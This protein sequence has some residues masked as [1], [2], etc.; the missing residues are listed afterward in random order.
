[1]P[2]PNNPN[3]DNGE[4]RHPWWK[5]GCA[6]ALGAGCLVPIT[7]ALLVGMGGPLFWPIMSIPLS[8]VGVLVGTMI[9]LVLNSKR[10]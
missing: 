8:L 3:S 1:M 6:G 9:W 2:S 4:T 7:L 5:F 10:K